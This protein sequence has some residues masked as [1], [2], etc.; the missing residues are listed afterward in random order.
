VSTVW[1]PLKTPQ[2]TFALTG[3][4]D[5]VQKAMLAV[6]ASA[7]H[8]RMRM[9]VPDDFRDCTLRARVGAVANRA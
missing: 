9:S 6:A 4:I 8:L 3:T 7:T 5:G 2:P 1:Y